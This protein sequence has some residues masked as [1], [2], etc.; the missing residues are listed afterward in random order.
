MVSV[1]AQVAASG[2]LTIGNGASKT[3]NHATLQNLGL[4]N[5]TSTDHFGLL[6]GAILSNQSGATFDIQTDNTLSYDGYGASAINNAGIFK[7]SSSGL[8]VVAIR[9]EEHTSELQSP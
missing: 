4:I 7:K 6:A 5:W 3:L 2:T 8:S 1:T 9:S